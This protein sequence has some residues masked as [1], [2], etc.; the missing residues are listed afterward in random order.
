MCVTCDRHVCNSHCY[1][2][3]IEDC[4]NETVC[5]ECLR[6][7]KV[8]NVW[9]CTDCVTDC[10]TCYSTGCRSCKLDKECIDCNKCYCE[11]LFL[12]D[13]KDSADICL[14]CCESK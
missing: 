9:V 8:C 4:E 5:D 10:E 14:K 6:F 11:C 13:D 7:C 2:C 3:G 12:I 1:K